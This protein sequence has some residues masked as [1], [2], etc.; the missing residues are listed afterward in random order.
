MWSPD[1]FAVPDAL[2]TEVDAIDPLA[3]IQYGHMTEAA[4][5]DIRLTLG[6]TELYPAALAETIQDLRA[7]T[8]TYC[9]DIESALSV[10]EY[11]HHSVEG[12]DPLYVSNKDL[13]QWL[14]VV[15][16][17]APN[18]ANEAL[19]TV[20]QCIVDFYDHDAFQIATKASRTKLARS[21]RES[22]VRIL[23]DTVDNLVDYGSHPTPDRL[24]MNTD[25][26]ADYGEPEQ[27]LRLHQHIISLTGR[28]DD[29]GLTFE[30]P[31]MKRLV[32]HYLSH[33][34]MRYPMR[35]PVDYH[36]LIRHSPGLLGTLAER[37]TAKNKARASF[38]GAAGAKAYLSI[39][40]R[41]RTPAQAAELRVLE[42]CITNPNLYAE[43]LEA[44]LRQD[45]GQL[46]TE[47]LANLGQ[48]ALGSLAEED[49][50]ARTSTSTLAFAIRRL[51]RQGHLHTAKWI[52]R[53]FRTLE[54]HD[55]AFLY[56]LLAIYEETGDVGSLKEAKHRRFAPNQ[57]G[58]AL[59]E[60]EAQEFLTR[61]YMAARRQGADWQA[62]DAAARL[63]HRYQHRVKPLRYRAR[64]QMMQAHLILGEM[65]AAQQ[66]ALR[67]HEDTH[68]SDEARF[69][70]MQYLSIAYA[71]LGNTA[72]ALHLLQSYLPT[73]STRLTTLLDWR[74]RIATKDYPTLPRKDVS[75]WDIHLDPTH[76]HPL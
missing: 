34:D 31:E 6:S 61:L 71:A 64:R 33:I 17:H 18:A 57:G 5:A 68:L 1:Q 51:A 69:E 66:Q 14:Q 67:I 60:G 74:R 21:L 27:R 36:S 29:H 10:N 3:V 13:R 37:H 35:P 43:Q 22:A 40:Q 63:E 47:E 56:N 73:N 15:H 25:L 45:G 42:T 2:R 62:E 19:G 49:P 30:Y 4:A 8:T 46:T 70:A 76:P 52:A 65:P 72:E 7:S 9:S 41:E 23:A 11:E 58:F 24:L 32:T 38:I 53:A 39:P 16:R 50:R 75:G 28:E 26:F 54:P 59:S 44:R 12:P 20:V 48:Y 55:P